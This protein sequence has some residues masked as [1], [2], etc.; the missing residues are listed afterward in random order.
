[1]PCQG[2][3]RAIRELYM[4]EFRLATSGNYRLTSRAPVFANAYSSLPGEFL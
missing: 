3:C 4:R 2:F 1:M